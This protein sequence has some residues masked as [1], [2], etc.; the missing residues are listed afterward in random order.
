LASNPKFDRCAEECVGLDGRAVR[1]MVANALA[2]DPETA[3]DPGRVTIDDLHA[4]AQAAKEA[5]V[6]K[7]KV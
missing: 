3:L 4:A 2:C 7:G 5:R 1:K 6:Q